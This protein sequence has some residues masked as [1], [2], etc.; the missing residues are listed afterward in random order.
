MFHSFQLVGGLPTKDPKHAQ[1]IAD[2][3]LL[4]R[5]AVQ[6]VKSPIDGSPIRIRIGL[7]SGPVMA[8]VVG[9]LMPRYCLFG[10]T[11]NTASRMESNGTAGLI[12]CS[13]KTA[14]ILM[15]AG[16]HQV[17]M[18]GDIEVKGKGIMTTYWLDAAMPHNE[19]SNGQAIARVETTVDNMLAHSPRD[20][21]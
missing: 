4:V 18:R 6:A 16:R 13:A 11:V 15:A 1:H 9:N 20:G 3:A 14:Q 17:T 19:H 7:H 2:F 8:G 12:H 21:E 10:D 5:S